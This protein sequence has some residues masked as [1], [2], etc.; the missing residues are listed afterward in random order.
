MDLSRRI[1]GYCERVG[2]EFW[3]EPL[4]AVT[5]GSF[6]LAALICLLTALR[7]GRLDA[8]V[9][10]LVVLMAIIGTGS[11]LFHTFATVWA[12]IADTTPIMIFILSYFAIAMNRFAG[13]GWG[14]SLLLMAAFFF[15]MGALS[16]GLRPLIGD[17]VG[18]SQ[19]YFPA[20]F[21]LLGVGLWLRARS[22]PAGPWLV[23]VA[24]VFAVSLTF[25]TLDGPLCESV[26]IGTHWLWHILNGA[27]LG[28]L[29]L[30]VIR[31][32]APARS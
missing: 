30:A 23:G 14:R 16:A 29:T 18:G 19:S 27:V 20:F 21:A 11:F 8:P 25:R 32:G 6:L 13:F 7:A 2:P 31:H 22:H 10:W 24:G 9:G 17:V 12:A 5:N 15:A 28:M 1:D 4:N 26:A 3:A